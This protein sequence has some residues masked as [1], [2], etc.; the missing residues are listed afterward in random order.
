MALTSQERSWAFS[1]D[2]MWLVESRSDGEYP[3][4]E[5]LLDDVFVPLAA[6]HHLATP[7]YQRAFDR[8]SFF[9]AL[10]LCAEWTSAG[11]HRPILHIECH[12]DVD[13]IQLA[14]GTNV[15]WPEVVGALTKI[16]RASRM[17]LAVVASMCAGVDL[18]GALAEPGRACAWAVIGPQYR[19]RAG[20]LASAN[21]RFYRTL[22]ATDS[23]MKAIDAMNEGAQAHDLTFR[24]LRAELLFGIAWKQHIDSLSG[25]KAVAD[26][27]IKFARAARRYLWLDEFPDNKH[28]FGETYASISEQWSPRSAPEPRDVPE[29][30]LRVARIDRL[31]RRRQFPDFLVRCLF[32]CG[33]VRR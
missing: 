20:D 18:C 30:S 13:G 27:S 26:V 7:Q 1:W 14:D 4:A 32:E 11:N 9:G 24:M 25:P 8:A 6:E 23:L 2:S 21:A 5:R 19:I 3:S 16:N 31:Q 17:N 33:G 28:R 29:H 12:G 15:L 22:A 10:D